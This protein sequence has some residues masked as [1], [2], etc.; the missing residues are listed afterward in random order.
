MNDD[1][2]KN[3]EVNPSE[4]IQDNFKIETTPVV[5]AKPVDEGNVTQT[6]V[7]ANDKVEALVEGAPLESTSG[8]E[9][10]VENSEANVVSETVI[11]ADINTEVE[12]V[13]Q[14]VMVG[15]IDEVS[16][17]V[18]SES[19]N[20]ISDNE[21]GENSV[22]K[23]P[24]TNTENVSM[25]E[26]Q[27]HVTERKKFPFFMVLVFILFIVAAFYIEDISNWVKEYK[28]SKNPTTDEVEN[29]NNGENE[30]EVVGEVAKELTLTEIK[31]AMDNSTDVINFEKEKNIEI[32]VI[33]EENKITYTTTNYIDPAATNTTFK[34]E[35]IFANNS[36]MAD[37]DMNNSTFGRQMSIFLVKEIAKLQGISAVDIDNYINEKADTN[38]L[39]NGFEFISLE[40]G[41]TSYKIAT[42]IRV[43]INK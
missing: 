5:A 6:V 10:L 11:T 19:F 43:D 3:V 26:G 33:V 30:E 14:E 40:D 18:D 27:E 16:I 23:K 25:K 12:E 34:V 32:T 13:K 41:D 35:Y 31:E 28:E 39:D 2:N 9:V 15:T 1:T 37:C 24:S 29:T 17:S 20:A 8:E 7:E 22:F 42:N 38:T 4:G 36:L 21:I